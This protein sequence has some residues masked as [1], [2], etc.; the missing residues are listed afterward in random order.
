MPNKYTDEIN[1]IIKRT[2]EIRKLKNLTVSEWFSIFL[3]DYCQNLKAS[4]FVSYQQA[5]KNH[6]N[7]ILGEVLLDD[8]SSEI[9]QFFIKVITNGDE[10]RQPLSPKTV[11]NVYGILHKGI[12]YAYRLGY[13]KS[14]IN[15]MMIVLPKNRQSNIKPLTNDEISALLN[16]ISNTQYESIIITALFTGMRESELLGLFWSD[17]DFQGGKITISRQLTRDKLTNQYALTSLK[18]DKPRTINPAPFIMKMLQNKF[19][20]D[21]ND[22]VFINEF[23]EHFSHN[24]VYRY[25]KK[26]A[27]KAFGRFDVRFHDLRHTYAVLSLQ[28]GDDY[29]TLQE[30]MGHYSA[31]FTLDRYGHCTDTMK[32]VSSQRME[33]YYKDVLMNETTE[34]Q[35]PLKITI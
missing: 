12:S 10:E 6:I 19:R 20:G 11:K 9:I 24:A 23:G 8:I 16:E 33:R 30:N 35:E 15:E 17:I 14:D 2:K 29:K 32:R 4:T 1:G 31:A 22:F 27:A 26:A 5:V 3:S 34:K 21:R 25:L 13:M 28:A 7:D 18:N